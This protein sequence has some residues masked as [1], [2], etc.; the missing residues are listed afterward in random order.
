MTDNTFAYCVAF[1]SNL[2]YAFSIHIF[3]HY[4]RKVSALW[5]NFIKAFIAMVL[6]FGTIVFM[7][8]SFAYSSS[9][10][11]LMILSGVLGT[12]IGDLAL[13]TALKELGPGR[14]MVLVAFHPLVT[15]ILSF[16]I[17]GQTLSLHK[18]IAILFMI[19]CIVIFS[20]ESFKKSGQWG[21]KGI[22]LV[23]TAIVLDAVGIILMKKVNVLSSINSFEANFYRCLGVVVFFIIWNYFKPFQIID[24]IKEQ[25]RRS[26]FIILAGAFLGTFMALFL[27]FVAYTTVKDN[28]ATIS[29]ISIS[30]SVFAT[31]IECVLEKKKPSPYLILSFVLM[32]CGVFIFLF[33]Q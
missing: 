1:T 22:L 29:S 31:I 12:G 14:A 20:F 16:F 8:Y 32:F 27:N 30:C 2:I 28:L 17:F 21:M 33:A 24:K 15:G 6:F 25:S 7:N 4:S 19:L 13:L 11:F 10:I 5:I 9:I 26:I 23:L 3:A 18:L